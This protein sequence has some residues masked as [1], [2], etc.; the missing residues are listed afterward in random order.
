MRM[1]VAIL[2]SRGIPNR[3][4]GF[5]ELA[6]KLAIGLADR[7]HE[8]VVYNPS[9]HPIKGW[10]HKGVQLVRVFNPEF[11]L[12]SF[13]QF[14]YDLGASIHTLFS[15]PDIILQL[16]YTSSSVWFWVLPRKAKII[17]NMDGLEWKRSKYSRLVQKFL[18]RAEK[19]AGKHSHL[20]IADNPEIE[21]YL[22]E[23]FVNQV[24]HIPYGADIPR[25]V[26]HKT[27]A[28]YGVEDGKYNLLIARLEPENHIEEILDGVKASDSNET[29]L[30]IGNTKNSFG[31]RMRRKFRPEK[32]IV[33][34]EGIYDK[35]ELNALRFHSRLYFHGHSVGGTNPSLLEA[36]ACSCFIVAHQNPFNKSVLGRNAWY[37]SN[38]EGVTA[39]IDK[40]QLASTRSNFIKRNVSTVRDKFNWR[41]IIEQYEIAMQQIVI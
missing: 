41:I 20:L 27:L 5:E 9:D 13:G 8:V 25:S 29:L 39:F 17:T 30:V 11:I 14:V 10:K 37:F 15:R 24:I 28:K 1:K 21:N 7:G 23:K 22:H 12:G 18:L 31:L 38:S 2:G 16:G 40:K 35:E 34:L 19:W 33:F 26:K 3:Y 32:R 6:E 4:G 36:M